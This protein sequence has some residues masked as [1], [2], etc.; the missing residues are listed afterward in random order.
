M[1]WGAIGPHYKS[2]LISVKGSMNALEYQNII[3]QSGVIEDMD[4][5]YGKHSWV[6]QEDG[7]SPDRAKSTRQFLAPQCMTLASGLHWPAHRPD[8]NVIANVWAIVK[9]EIGKCNCQKPED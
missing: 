1:V 6:C 8:L 4:R 2:P 3:R 9:S 5:R 7:A